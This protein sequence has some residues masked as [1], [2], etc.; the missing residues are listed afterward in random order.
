MAWLG[1]LSNSLFAKKSERRSGRLCVACGKL[2]GINDTHC[3]H[4]QT[5]QTAA[6]QVAKNLS[7]VLPSS[8]TATTLILGLMAVLFVLPIVAMSGHPAFDLW[9][10][11]K[12]SLISDIA[13]MEQPAIKLGIN[14]GPLLELGQYW[15]LLTAT[16]LH[17]GIMHIAFN[18]YALHILGP[19]TEDLYDR[20]WFAFMYVATGVFGNVVSWVGHGDRFLQAGASGSVFGLMG[21]GIVY[22]WRTGWRNRQ[23]LNLLITW[24]VL[25]I[26][27]GIFMGADN[28][29]HIGGLVAGAVFAR[30][31]PPERV[32]RRNGKKV[33]QVLGALTL[34]T[35][36][37]CFLLALT[38]PANPF[39][40]G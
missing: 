12:S 8:V 9:E 1:A 38:Q 28:Y 21:I 13:D 33:G 2:V 15:R 20:N 22:C 11:L 30:L 39:V 14:F 23:M 36:I 37:G 29:A 3:P 32:T 35:V 6:R 17:F 16:F 40:S 18:S 26:L 4:C 19:M 27:F 25:S 31:L 5:Q 10:Y 24:S 7:G 34:L